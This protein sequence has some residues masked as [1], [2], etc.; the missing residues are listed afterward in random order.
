MRLCAIAVI[1][2]ALAGCVAASTGS[3]SGKAGGDT[4]ILC[5]KG[6]QTMELPDEAAQG[7]LNHGDQPG[8]C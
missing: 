1:V 4:V 2:L 5:H 6:K 8:P 3:T 7:H